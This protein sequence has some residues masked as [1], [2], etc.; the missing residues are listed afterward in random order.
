L[1]RPIYQ[2]PS[3]LYALFTTCVVSIIGDGTKTL[4]WIQR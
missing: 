3:Q 4:F 1:D 2:G